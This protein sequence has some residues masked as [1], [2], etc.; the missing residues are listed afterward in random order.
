MPR[1]DRRK[2]FKNQVLYLL[3]FDGKKQQQKTPRYLSP[4]NLRSN[5]G[6]QVCLSFCLPACTNLGCD[7]AW[8]EVPKEALT[9]YVHCGGQTWSR[10]SKTASSTAVKIPVIS[11]QPNVPYQDSIQHTYICKRLL[12]QTY[13]LSY[14]STLS[15]VSRL[16]AAA[17]QLNKILSTY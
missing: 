12:A 10:D 1:T 14:V 7:P 13:S 4:F 17:L 2:A 16:R 15:A 8:A 5:P 11:T 9:I 3:N 6:C